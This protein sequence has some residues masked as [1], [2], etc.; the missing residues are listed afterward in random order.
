MG[1]FVQGPA[2]VKREKELFEQVCSFENLLAAAHKARRGKR[3]RPDVA[4][5][6][7]DLE[8]QALLLQSELRGRQYRPLGYRTFHVRDPKPRMISAAAYRD[9]VVHHALCNVIEP[10]FE[11]SFIHDS[12]GCR[13]GKGSHAA[14]DRLTRFMR[15]TDYILKCDIRRFFPSIDHALLKER[16]RRKVGCPDTLWLA[17]LIIDHS[18]EQEPVLAYFAGDDLFTPHERRR[19]LPLG[20]QTSQF[21]ANVY[22]DGLDHHIK[23]ALGCRRYIR[24]VDD[25]AVLDDDKRTLW[26]V[27]DAIADYAGS[28]LRLKLHPVKQTVT[29]TAVGVDFLGY[30]VFPD[31]RLL[32]RSTT[33][34][35]IRRLGV[36]QRAYTRGA[37]SLTEV[38]QSVAAW[39]GHARHADTY[40]L[41]TAALGAVVLRRAQA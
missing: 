19:G 31:H 12:Y 11:R 35:F 16:I 30:R 23:E 38:S 17:D 18:N 41:R 4:R 27:R 33:V 9:R 39:V 37:V 21:F 32:R 22:L 2:A 7:H 14:V 36:M 8:P 1:A 28:R 6:E 24:Y 15:S 40:G 13:P 20:N 29:P 10:I 5:F 26:D 3:F 25:F 34:R